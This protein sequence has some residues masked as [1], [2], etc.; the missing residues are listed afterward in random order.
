MMMGAMNPNYNRKLLLCGTVFVAG[1]T[2]LLTG[3]IDSFPVLFFMRMVHA[4][5]FSLTIPV[6]SS[7]VRAYFPQQRRGLAN[8]LLY[9]ASYL[10]IAIS[11]LSVI[12]INK[13]GWRGTYCVMGVFGIVTAFL[14]NLSIK[15]PKS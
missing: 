1:L 4:A 5:C 8:S 7:L 14:S 9:S 13:L 11:S 3:V 6:V 15:E 2:S 12:L 10:G